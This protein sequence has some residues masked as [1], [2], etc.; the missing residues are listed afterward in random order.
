MFGNGRMAKPSSLDKLRNGILD[1]GNDPCPPFFPDVIK[2]LV[3]REI[4]EEFDFLTRI[5]GGASRSRREKRQACDFG[6]WRVR[7]WRRRTEKSLP[8][9][10]EFTSPRAKS[11]AGYS[12]ILKTQ[13]GSVGHAEKRRTVAFG[14]A[15]Q[16]ALGP[17]S[18]AASNHVRPRSAMIVVGRESRQNRPAADISQE[19]R[20]GRP[21][22]PIQL[23]RQELY[24]R[25]WSTPAWKLGHELGYSGLGFGTACGGAHLL[26]NSNLVLDSS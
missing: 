17:A 6:G 22:D 8:K 20:R 7:R 2:A 21:D 3:P 1:I 4:Q 16:H 23:T 26:P 14:I 10:H 5:T 11:E 9:T 12:C 15:M 19:V 13:S 25:V 18:T 24:D